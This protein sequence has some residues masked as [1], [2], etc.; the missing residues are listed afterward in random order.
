MKFQRRTFFN[1]FFESAKINRR[2]SFC[3]GER[4]TE[5]APQLVPTF[6]ST[7]LNSRASNF[8]T[9][10]QSTRSNHFRRG[11]AAIRSTP[12]RAGGE[13][14]SSFVH[15]LSGGGCLYSLHL[16]PS[17]YNRRNSREP[18]TLKMTLLH[19]LQCV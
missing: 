13:G 19:K 2:I 7:R 11:A 12:S 1:Q 4:R 10:F 6:R 14:G 9:S 16:H 17:R 15:Y 8:L 18:T 3:N 5:C